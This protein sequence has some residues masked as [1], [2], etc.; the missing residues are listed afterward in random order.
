MGVAVDASLLL[1]WHF[2]DEP[3]PSLPYRQR[4]INDEVFVPTHFFTELAN[5]V[6]VAERRKRTEARHLPGLFELLDS[7][8]PQE[9]VLDAM[10][11]LERILPLARAHGLTV[12]D[13][14]YLELAARRGLAIATGDRALARAARSA[15]LEVLQEEA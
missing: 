12:Y 11:V 5:A 3:T 8:R 6:L 10:A 13:A 9:D 4:L 15:G 2:S 7:L 1:R 14:L